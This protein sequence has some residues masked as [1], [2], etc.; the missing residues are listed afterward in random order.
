MKDQ[1]TRVPCFFAMISTEFIRSLAEKKLGET[2]EE[3]GLYLVDVTV[4]ASNKIRVTIDNMHGGISIDQCVS[5]SRWIENQLDRDAE[6]FELEVSSPGLDQPFRVFRQYQK[7]IGKEV[8]LKLNDGSRHAGK[9]VGAT[10]EQV[11]IEQQTKEKL[12]GK[13]GKQ[14]VIRR[15]SFPMAEIKETRKVIK[16]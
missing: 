8:E 10:Q 13:K 14:P 6:D 11:E 5:M 3:S 4:S 16:F 2:G 12:E 1:G 15:L 9:L 7:N